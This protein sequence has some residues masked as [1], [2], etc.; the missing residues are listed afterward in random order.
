M[1]FVRQN[2]NFASDEPLYKS[3]WYKGKIGHTYTKA[4]VRWCTRTEAPIKR[5]VLEKLRRWHCFQE[6][7]SKFSRYFLVSF[8]LLQHSKLKKAIKESK[9][10]YKVLPYIRWGFKFRW[11]ISSWLSGI[12]IWLVRIPKMTSHENERKRGSRS[13]RTKTR[14]EQRPNEIAP[15]LRHRKQKRM[16]DGNLGWVDVASERG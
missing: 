9:S 2:S 16:K 11:Q 8:L 3:V 5:P 14:R 7:S 6:W 13:W 1:F 15:E 12:L 10:G 4:D